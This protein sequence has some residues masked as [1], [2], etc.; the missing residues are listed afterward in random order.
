M[1]KI[2]RMDGITLLEILIAAAIL[3]LTAMFGLV[4]YQDY[5]S[6]TKV[7]EGLM[8]TAGPKAELIEYYAVHNEFPT[9]DMTYREETDESKI[10]PFSVRKI[11]WESDGRLEIWFGGDDDQ[12]T[13]S[14]GI[15]WL[16]PLQ[17]GENIVWQ[18]QE[19]DTHGF[20]YAAVLP[21][22]CRPQ[23]P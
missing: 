3:S 13:S 21:S 4:A 18:C 23:T 16:I 10:T 20:E 2:D 14:N 6:R 22:N 17:T 19:D 12:A 15:L 8:L 9:V 7:A 5:T 11:K 1:G